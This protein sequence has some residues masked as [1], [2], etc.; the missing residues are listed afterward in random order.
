MQEQQNN[1]SEFENII[2]YKFNNIE[3]LVQALSHPSINFNKQKNQP[4]EVNYERLEFLG[5]SI[6]NFVIA[7]FLFDKFNR[8]REGSLAKRRAQLVCKDSLAQISLEI[9]LDKYM[10][11]SY[12]EEKSGGR[13]NKNNLENVLEAV[14]AAIYLDSN[15][16]RVKEVIFRIFGPKLSD[17]N[18][19][20]IDSK[21]LLQEW[22]QARNLGVPQYFIEQESGADHKPVFKAKV[23]LGDEYFAHSNGT[24]KK[25]AE[26]HAAYE[27]LKILKVI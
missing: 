14:I 19:G 18:F 12:G 17:L 7:E 10:I 21:T 9:S 16:K 3:I 1:F 22:S 15:I 13:H 26:K 27:M 4:Q 11:M 2:S 6:L 8:V 24:S 23:C 25:Q 20:N 5:D